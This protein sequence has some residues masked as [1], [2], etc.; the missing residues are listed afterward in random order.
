MMWRGG[1][2]FERFVMVVVWFFWG[3]LLCSL[4]FCCTGTKKRIRKRPLT[5]AQKISKMNKKSSMVKNWLNNRKAKILKEEHAKKT[6]QM[7]EQE[8]YN[9]LVF[10]SSMYYETISLRDFVQEIFNGIDHENDGRIRIEM[11]LKAIQ[12]NKDLVEMLKT[13]MEVAVLGELGANAH[14]DRELLDKIDLDHD[15]WLTVTE[16]LTF[17]QEH[18]EEME[19]KERTRLAQVNKER[20]EQDLQRK[21]KEQ[22]EQQEQ[23]PTI[24]LERSNSLGLVGGLDKD[25]V[26]RIANAAE[27]KQQ[28]MNAA[29][30]RKDGR[31]GRGGGRQGRKVKR[32]QRPA[33]AGHQRGSSRRRFPKR[34]RWET[35]A[36]K[37]NQWKEEGGGQY[38]QTKILSERKR[39]FLKMKENFVHSYAKAM[40]ERKA[41]VLRA[42]STRSLSNFKNARTNTEM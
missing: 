36:A 16:L 2:T 9:N 20:K 30:N 27:N 5:Q 37:K 26:A 19:I 35:M 42:S 11:L 10:P 6:Q 29:K 3:L 7:K 13:R 28:R 39:T 8:G 40:E 12:Y 15:G 14:E 31:G 34:E 4:F 18:K 23:Q 22:Q 33:S 25:E 41:R 32:P 17:A 24:Q 21:K 38:S 1:L